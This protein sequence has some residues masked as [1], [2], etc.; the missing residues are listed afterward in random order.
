[1]GNVVGSESVLLQQRTIRR[2]E[3]ATAV[4]ILI[5][6]GPHVDRLMARRRRHDRAFVSVDVIE[7]GPRALLGLADTHRFARQELSDFSVA[8]VKIACNDGVLGAH[9][10]ARWLKANL[11]AVGAEMALGRRTFIGIDINGIVGT[12]LHAGLASDAALRTEIDDAVFPLVHR[13]D[14]ADGYARRILTVIAA[15]HLK[16]ASSV[17][18]CSLLDIFHP[19]AIHRERNMILRFAGHGASVTADALAVIDDESVS[20]SG[21]LGC[22]TQTPARLG[23]CSRPADWH[24]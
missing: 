17:G 7:L 19:G 11:S 1:M 3:R 18:E 24:E 5:S 4:N 8:G 22:A 21:V 23:Y 9:H 20:H 12:G 16:D 15:R 10:Y 13:R 6:F 2:I 14:R